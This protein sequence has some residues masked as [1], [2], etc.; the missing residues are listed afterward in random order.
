LTIEAVLFDADGVLQRPAVRWRHAF[1]RLL[2]F[3]AMSLDTFMRDVLAAELSVLCASAGFEDVLAAVLDRW[4]CSERLTDALRVLTAIEVYDDVMEAVYA[5]KLAQ[6]GH[7]DFMVGIP[8]Y[9]DVASHHDFVVQDDGAFDQTMV[10]FH[11]LARYGVRIEVRI[12][13]H[14]QT[15]ERLPKLAEYIYRNLPF[16]EHVAFMG[17]EMMG[18]TKTNLKRCGLIPSTTRTCLKRRCHA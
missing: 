13:V 14:K 1:E 12:V 4:N 3:D 11:N 7:P 15:W 5:A 9:S 6:V 2:G 8:L 17:L 18:Y 16:V 10:G